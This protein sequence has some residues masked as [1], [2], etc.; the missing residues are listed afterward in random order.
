MKKNSELVWEFSLAWVAFA[1]GATLLAN[2]FPF[3][4]IYIFGLLFV[5]GFIFMLISFGIRLH[6]NYHPVS[7]VTSILLVN[8]LDNPSLGLTLA[9]T[10]R[11]KVNINNFVSIRF[12]KELEN[13]LKQVA[14]FEP[15][16]FLNDANVG[17]VV[18]I[19]SGQYIE[20]SPN[21]ELHLRPG[22]CKND[23]EKV[24]FTGSK[25]QAV[26]S[27]IGHK[28]SFTKLDCINIK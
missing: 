6:E 19:E 11:E 16:C 26:W 8:T 3:I 7:V 9:F 12:S 5:V 4:P 13:K 14:T 10:S 20:C 17:G 23:I 1:G 2:F 18:P 28:N 27:I 22:C 25:V 24:D 15:Y 21:I